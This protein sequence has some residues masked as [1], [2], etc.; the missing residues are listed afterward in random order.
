[1]PICKSLVLAAHLVST[2]FAPGYN[3]ENYGVGVECRAETFQ[4]AA[5]TY[6]NSFKRTS[7]YVAVGRDFFEAGPVAVGAVAGLVSGY[8]HVNKTPLLGGLRLSAKFG[9][10]RATVL[11]FPPAGDTDG[12]AH[13]MLGWEFDMERR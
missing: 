8:D 4:L 10:V 2:H 5:G 1:M 6:R 3:N 7:N 9:S 12:L 13:L 11:G